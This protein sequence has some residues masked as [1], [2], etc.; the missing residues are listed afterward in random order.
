MATNELLTLKTTVRCL[1]LAFA[2]AF[3]A[4]PARAAARSQA[5]RS[6]ASRCRTHCSH[7]QLHPQLHP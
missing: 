2:H 7:P 6:Q 5:S 4:M 1:R 3:L